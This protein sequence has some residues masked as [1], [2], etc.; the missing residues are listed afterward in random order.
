MKKKYSKPTI[1]IILMDCSDMIAYSN[2]P[3]A[4]IDPEAEPTAPSS[5]ESRGLLN[6]WDDEE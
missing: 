6:I 2:I 4:G 5:I 1:N 3:S